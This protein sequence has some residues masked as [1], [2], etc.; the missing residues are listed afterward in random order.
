MLYPDGNIRLSYVGS[1]PKFYYDTN[2]K[3]LDL[4]TIFDAINQL[5]N[6]LG[7]N[8]QSSK[9]TRVDWGFNVHVVLPPSQYIHKLQTH[10]RL[11]LRNKKNGTLYFQTKTGKISLCFYDKKKE[12]VSKKSF[13]EEDRIFLESNILRYEIRIEG[14]V[15]AYLKLSNN[16]LKN[17]LTDYALKRINNMWR[18]KYFEIQKEAS[19][20]DIYVIPNP[21]A[22]NALKDFLSFLGIQVIGNERL[23]EMIS[24]TKFNILDP[25]VKRSKWK[26]TV[27]DINSKF[28]SQSLRH[29]PIKELDE[30]IEFIS[31]STF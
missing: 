15:D 21:N 18:D 22:R 27:K 3:S 9:I 8:L 13:E 25:T 16:Y 26:R 17:V 24:S 20:Q 12:I 23:F 4:Y 14:R 10:S 6:E 5:S 1:L 11:N 19:E 7:T 28:S 29:Y 2:L 31:K 30:K